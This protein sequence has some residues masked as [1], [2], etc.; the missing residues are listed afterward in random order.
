MTLVEMPLWQEQ[1]PMPANLGADPL[2]ASTDVAIVGG[3]YTGLW[4]AIR[5]KETEPQPNQAQGASNSALSIIGSMF[6]SLSKANRLYGS[7]P[8]ALK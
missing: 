7:K 2:P 3:G 1:A 4:T 5:L 8:R 6:A